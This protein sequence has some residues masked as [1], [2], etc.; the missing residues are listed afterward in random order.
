MAPFLLLLQMVSPHHSLPCLFRRQLINH[1]HRSYRPSSRSRSRPSISSTPH[2]TSLLLPA[3]G[4]LRD[5]AQHPSPT[6]DRRAHRYSNAG[7]CQVE[8]EG[9]ARVADPFN[10]GGSGKRTS[11]QAEHRQQL[12]RPELASLRAG[13]HSRGGATDFQCRP[14][15]GCYWTR[16]A[17]R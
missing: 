2:P 7:W 4:P 16:R 6:T 5:S 10:E 3:A 11:G 14:R 9:A 17:V 13:S 15:C 1:L 8:E 12:T